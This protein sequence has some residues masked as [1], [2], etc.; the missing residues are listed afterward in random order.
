V[1]LLEIAPVV[2]LQV[3]PDTDSLRGG[4]PGHLVIAT[5]TLGRGEGRRLRH[6]FTQHDQDS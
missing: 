4:A 5:P 2:H 1:Q 6:S 3:D